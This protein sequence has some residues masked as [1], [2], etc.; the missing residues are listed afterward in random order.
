MGMLALVIYLMFMIIPLRRLRR[1]ELETFQTGAH[2]KFFY[3][4]VGIQA[5]LVAY[6]VSSFFASVAYLW[7]I[8]YLVIYAVCLRRIYC[9]QVKAKEE[10]STMKAAEPAIVTREQRRNRRDVNS[11]PGQ[12]DS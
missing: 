4:A 11:I 10:Q 12:L 8:Y 9:V 3:L 7:N 2:P 6:L 5:S 1:I